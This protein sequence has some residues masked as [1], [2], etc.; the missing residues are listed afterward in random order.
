MTEPASKE[1]NVYIRQLP[2]TV[3]GT[4]LQALR[5]P[6]SLAETVL[7]RGS[8]ADPWAPALVFDSFGANVKQFVGSV[9]GDPELA[10]QGRLQQAK[11]TE[12]R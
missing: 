3:V 8:D 12:L 10:N 5:L 6:I 9:V 2:R 7:R 11:V 1:S 4:Y